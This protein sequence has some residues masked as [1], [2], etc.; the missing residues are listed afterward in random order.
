MIDQY[1]FSS[2][3]NCKTTFGYLTHVH[4]RCVNDKILSRE[5]IICAR[6]FHDWGYQNYWNSQELFFKLDISKKTSG[7]IFCDY[8]KIHWVYF[9]DQHQSSKLK[10]WV[11]YLCFDFGFSAAYFL[12]K[13]KCSPSLYLNCS[14]DNVNMFL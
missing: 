3:E 6:N 5:E 4:P 2:K 10:I 12:N 1:F 9:C 11:L 7:I 14:L 8:M 13:N